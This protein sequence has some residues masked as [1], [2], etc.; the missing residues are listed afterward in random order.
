MI[1]DTFPLTHYFASRFCTHTNKKKHDD[2]LIEETIMPNSSGARAWT[3]S[4]WTTNPVL[5]DSFRD[6]FRTVGPRLE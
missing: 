2:P 4:T 1:H 6:K 5:E 3:K